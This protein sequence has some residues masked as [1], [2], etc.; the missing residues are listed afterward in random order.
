MFIGMSTKNQNSGNSANNNNGGGF[1][2]FN[3]L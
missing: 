2:E 1:G 3:L